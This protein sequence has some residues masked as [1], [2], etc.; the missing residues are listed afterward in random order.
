MY[1]R[2]STDEQDLQRQE[3]IQEDA[4]QAGYYIAGVYREDLGARADR[5][6]LLRMIDDLQYGEVVVVSEG[7][8]TECQESTALAA[9]S[10]A[11]STV[12]IFIS[13]LHMTSRVVCTA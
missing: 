3:R 13:R 11:Y 8:C 9:C 7:D 4:R 6:E 5:P 2:V 10:A 12:A 1:L